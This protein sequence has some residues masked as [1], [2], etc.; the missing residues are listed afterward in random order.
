M[1]RGDIQEVILENLIDRLDIF[2]GG[3][4]FWVV[5][6]LAGEDCH[7]SLL[8]VYHFCLFDYTG[9]YYLL[10]WGFLGLACFGARMGCLRIDGILGT[11]QGLLILGWAGG[12][13]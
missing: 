13:V 2:L 5:L 12:F 6:F 11:G 9:Y 4:A 1:Y 8:L 7:K 10:D 3:C